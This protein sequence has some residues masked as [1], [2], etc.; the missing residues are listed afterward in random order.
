MGAAGEGAGHLPEQAMTAEP[1]LFIMIRQ[2]DASG[3]SGPGRVLDGVVFPNG[4]TVVCWRTEEVH[5]HTSVGVYDSFEAFKLIHIDSPPT[6]GTEVVWLPARG[7]L[8]TSGEP[9][10]L[11]D[12][13]FYA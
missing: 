12:A 5:G 7:G 13:C 3:V 9:V 4:K 6:N 1:K 2:A 8:V 11:D 10:S